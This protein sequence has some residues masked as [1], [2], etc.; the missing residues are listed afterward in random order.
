MAPGRKRGANKPKTNTEFSLGDLVLAKVKG[1][2]AWP[3]KVSKP[4][5][6]ERAPDAKKYFVQFFGTQEIAF[7]APA[8][9]YAF[10]SES[11]S[12]LLVKCRGKTVKYFPQAVTE[13]CEAFEQ[14]QQ[15]ELDGSRKHIGAAGLRSYASDVE[16]GKFKGSL[17]EVKKEHE[18]EGLNWSNNV[19]K[20]GFLLGDCPSTE[21]MSRC[22]HDNQA[23][24]VE[25]SG[26]VSVCQ[27]FKKS[28]RD[29][30]HKESGV[31]VSSSVVP[32]S[33][34]EELNSTENKVDRIHSSRA[35]S[36]SP[37]GCRS[38][39]ELDTARG[40]AGKK[41]NSFSLGVSGR[42]KVLAHGDKK[43]TNGQKSKDATV[44]SKRKHEGVV[45]HIDDGKSSGRVMD[46]IP[47]KVGSSAN[48]KQL[49]PGSNKSE[50]NSFRKITRTQMKGQKHL[51]MGKNSLKDAVAYSKDRGDGDLSKQKSGAVSQEQSHSAKKAKHM[52]MISDAAKG[53]IIK[54]G[55]NNVESGSGSDEA[56]LPLAKRHRRALEGMPD[57]SV[58]SE[59]KKMHCPSSYKADVPKKRRAVRLYDDEDEVPKTPVHGGSLSSSK[60]RSAV[61]PESTKSTDGS[62]DI[63]NCQ[64]EN[65][66]CSSEDMSMED[67]P[68]TAKLV[69][70]SSIAGTSQEK[71]DSTVQAEASHSPGTEDLDNRPLKETNV[72]LISP[73]KSPVVV[74]V[75]KLLDQQ[76]SNRPPVKGSTT[77]SHSK[78]HNGS[79]K[80]PNLVSG[81]P[82]PSQS[83][84]S[85]R[86][87]KQPL[88]GEKLK[89]TPKLTMR[90]EP[91][92]L[93]SQRDKGSMQGGRL[94]DA[95]DKSGSVVD[96]K[97][98]ESSLSIKH[99]IA[100][101]QAR[102]REAH[103]QNVPL[104]NGNSVVAPT[105]IHR[106]RS[107]SPSSGDQAF[108]KSGVDNV[109]PPD[110]LGAHSRGS[111]GSPSGHIR[112]FTS[113]SQL[114]SEEPEERRLSSTHQAAG[115]TLSGGT[116]AAVARDAFEG[117]I[118]T[119]SRTK[120][121]IGRATRLAIDCAKYGIANEVVDLLIRKLEN[122][123]S[124][125][126]RVDLFFLV[127]S[128][129]QCSHSQKG[130]AGA[131]YIPT[132]QAA[133]PRLLGAAA[134][135]GAS[136]REN[137]RQCLKVLRLWL[138]RK[139]LPESVLQRHMD[140][141]GGTNDDVGVGLS[142]RRPSRAERSVDDPIRE[143]EGMLVDEY[144]SNATF[145]LPG[146]L[147]SRGFV[148]EEDEDDV[149]TTTCK[150]SDPSPRELL[151]SST[152]A[153]TGKI[154]PIDRQHHILEDVDGELEMEDVSGHLKDGAQ[155][156]SG[157]PEKEKQE[158]LLNTGF[159]SPTEDVLE[160]LS[161]EGSPP[162]P[163]EPPPALPP[164]PSSPYPPPPPPLSPSPP[165]PPP[166]P[167]SLLSQP[168]PPP[169]ITSQPPPP[170]LL[171]SQ[172][173]PPPSLASQPPPPPSLSSH[174][175]PPPLL[176]SG[177]P[178]PGHFQPLLPQQPSAPHQVLPQPPSV[179]PP[180]QA[181]LP[182][183]YSIPSGSQPVQ[184]AGNT[185]QQVPCFATVGSSGSR[186]L[187]G[188]S[189][190]PLEYGQNDIYP[191]P[192]GGQ[193]NKQFQHNQQFQPAFAQRPFP[194]I[195][196]PQPSSSNFTFNKPAVQQHMP[197]SHPP[198]PAHPPPP[199]PP[200]SHLYSSASQ[201]QW[202]SASSEF[203]VDNPHNTWV[204]G[205][206]TPVCPTT[207]FVGEA[208]FRPPER[209]PPNVGYQVSA[210]NP[211]LA[212]PSSQGHGINQMLP[213]MSD[214]SALSCWRPV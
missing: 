152:E 36:S 79:L 89:G 47:G 110:A 125:H 159:E 53:S 197:N 90:N 112:N 120:D 50:L 146:F 138:Q 101:A 15:N 211:A 66:K 163:L 132:V 98:G 5:D 39:I 148:D 106:V 168:L 102:R 6:W 48:G 200:P 43:A 182:P 10:T 136:A 22:P 134:P 12:R 166:P 175:P 160:P 45:R 185:S 56:V 18:C 207:T 32:S 177:P 130:I 19:D 76:K 213:P 184:M 172:P 58:P 198:P 81:A 105:N 206:R 131:S 107:P 91:A 171:T 93:D 77:G 128:I 30:G 8:D 123:P 119:L 95:K 74:S 42:G 147:H 199:P 178:Q 59:D 144:G 83:Q 44:G 68:P 116:E 72:D 183:D 24:T 203:K 187:P 100:A 156:P 194:H 204:S 195:P 170:S 16:R 135:S 37:Y 202:R 169:S 142:L 52:D 21:D 122:E 60:V 137:R 14:L 69:S 82:N 141:I 27:T 103:V 154:T 13:I 158:T 186:D 3:A 188:Y 167:P 55:K 192:Q 104:G 54:N 11:K 190:R 64:G 35:S 161:P 70:E 124:F 17:A 94:E 63:S 96:P 38:D 111:V 57:A 40:K 71:I 210:P 145:N 97:A 49:S 7:V 155:S 139:I 109:T 108:Q 26:G 164:L 84:V 143:M 4:E 86:K 165:P 176:P 179:H 129:T 181:P 85:A 157:S 62:R 67:C 65:L 113:Q 9:V 191:G 88:S 205:G 127:D 193:P 209:P 150:E 212:G 28:I 208:Y 117:M 61:N 1:F 201:V 23:A 75:N 114:D 29:G 121:S 153:E 78:A 2:P 162:M 151:N 174:L 92:A 189:S 214:M 33:I 31:P 173:P 99:L 34:K 115:S 41:D 140:D 118:E 80:G 51:D 149:P 46:R 87:S 73:S 25:E 20:S 180:M 133:L 196:V 126:R